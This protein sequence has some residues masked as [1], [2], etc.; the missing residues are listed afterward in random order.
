MN[1]D[2]LTSRLV[3]N[4]KTIDD[5]MRGGGV[6]AVEDG[7]VMDVNAPPPAP[8]RSYETTTLRS[9]RSS[10][11]KLEDIMV[12]REDIAMSDEL[13][14]GEFGTVLSG[15]WQR[16]GKAPLAVAVKRLKAESVPP[17]EAEGFRREATLMMPCQHKYVVKLLGIVLDPPMMM[18]C[19]LVQHGAL[20]KYLKK[21]ADEITAQQQITWI[22]QIAEGM[23][24]L[25]SMSMVH[26]DL[27]ARWVRLRCRPPERTRL[28]AGRALIG[29]PCYHTFSQEC[30]RCGAQPCKNHRFR[31]FAGTGLQRKL[32]Q[33]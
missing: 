4:A 2:G 31:A 25:E 16:R 17:S 6:T 8:R 12:R 7:Y 30:S 15:V 33:V 29:V 11:T 22:K 3:D 24:Y 20:N 21:H 23:D 1:A 14:H 5:R 18:I 13:G 26:R 27:A 10:A 28:L 9:A 19:E 32:L